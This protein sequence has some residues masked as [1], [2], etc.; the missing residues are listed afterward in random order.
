MPLNQQP[1]RNNKASSRTICNRRFDKQRRK[2][3]FRGGGR[4]KCGSFH[5]SHCPIDLSSRSGV[6]VDEATLLSKGPSFCPV[7]RDINWHRCHL[8]WQSFVDK[9]R[10]ADFYFD[11]NSVDISSSPDTLDDNLGPF[12]VKSGAR[13]PVSKD[14]AL[15]TFLATI[16]TN[17]LMF[18]EPVTTLLA[19]YLSQN[20][21]PC[22]GCVHLKTL[23][24]DC[25]TKVQGLLSWIKLITLTKSSLT[26]M[27]AHL[28]YYP[29]ISHPL[30]I[31]WLGTGELNG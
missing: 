10:W 12:Q 17:Y 2:R 4:H 8:D 14:I 13:A 9:V 3:S 29:L 26:S 30:I 27:M 22:T 23:L 25:K 18:I 20:I 5:S 15:E 11:R 19:T 16:E 31:K 7:P 1:D 6:L 24:S 21:K 28:I